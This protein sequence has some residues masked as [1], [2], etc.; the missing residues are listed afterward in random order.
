VRG[1]GGQG[2]GLGLGE[3]LRAEVWR[4]CLNQW[5]SLAS[6]PASERFLALL[7]QPGPPN[8][9][10][11]PASTTRDP[12]RPNCE[13][14]WCVKTS[15]WTGGQFVVS[16]QP[17]T[18][19]SQRSAEKMRAH[20]AV[21]YSQHSP[22]QAEQAAFPPASGIFCKKRGAFEFAPTPTWP[23]RARSRR[24]SLEHHQHQRLHQYLLTGL[25]EMVVKD[26]ASDRRCAA[27]AGSL[28]DAQAEQR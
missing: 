26:V 12:A 23:H 3:A 18:G 1:P 20:Q 2:L 25:N 9:P 7:Q 16:T 5:P 15:Y 14:E 8:T 28:V 27:N 4:R 17:L 24:M 10:S 11:P 13:H 6:I 19:V 21:I 22:F